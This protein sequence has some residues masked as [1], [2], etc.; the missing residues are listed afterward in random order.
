MAQLTPKQ[1]K[2][3]HYVAEGLTGSEA[4]RRVYATGVSGRKTH[5]ENASRVKNNPA[6]KAYIASIIAEQRAQTTLTRQDVLARLDAII[7]DPDIK[8]T[9]RVQAIKTR[10]EMTGDNAPQEVNI[11][12]LSDLLELVRAKSKS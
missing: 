1:I 2:F 5:W 6:V 11:F 3:A 9:A 12:G 4:Y 10:N 8:P 7:K